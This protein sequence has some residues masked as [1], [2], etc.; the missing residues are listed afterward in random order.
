MLIGRTHHIPERT[1][2]GCRTRRTAAALLRLACDPEGNVFLDVS[3]RFPGRG[4][5]VCYDAGCMRQAL[6]VP[7]LQVALKRP[8][9]LLVF[10]TLYEAAIGVLNKRLG[11]YLSMAQKAGVAIS[12]AVPLRRALLQQRIRYLVLAEDIA[13]ARAEAYL[14]WCHELQ[15]PSLSLFSKSELGRLLGKEQRSAVGLSD[16]RFGTMLDETTAVLT[17]LYASAGCLRAPYKLATQ[18]S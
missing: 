15:I 6:H 9:T 3:G 16:A 12:G 1:C 2:L 17:Q 4:A 8:V 11:S 13:P 14:G 5:Y 7:R 18:S 10:D